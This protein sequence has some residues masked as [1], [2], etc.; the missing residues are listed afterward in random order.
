[1]AFSKSQFQTRVLNISKQI[2]ENWCLCQY[3]HK[4]SKTFSTYS[5]WK[6]EL[7][8][9]LDELNTM[10]TDNGRSREKWS[11]EILR[12]GDFDDAQKV[13]RQCQ[14]ICRSKCVRTSP[15]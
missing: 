13:F 12:K 11:L 14:R 5:H 2:A 3:C 6:S 8:G 15:A 4:Y 10:S 9:C 1:M 7:E